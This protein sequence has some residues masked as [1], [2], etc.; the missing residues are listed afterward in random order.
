MKR[1]TERFQI[2]KTNGNSV[3]VESES[4]RGNKQQHI[5]KAG[6]FIQTE[7]DRRRPT[8]SWVVWVR[9]GAFHNAGY[10]EGL[11][12]PINKLGER[13]WHEVGLRFWV[14]R[15]MCA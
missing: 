15:A 6:A 9:H 8:A 5:N 12:E 4:W 3:K 10:L 14:K 7:A 13:R 11:D 1:R 2:P